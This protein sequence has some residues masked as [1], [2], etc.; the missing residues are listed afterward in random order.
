MHPKTHSSIAM[1]FSYPPYKSNVRGGRLGGRKW[2][3]RT[4]PPLSRIQNKQLNVSE[5]EWVCDIS[6]TTVINTLDFWRHKRQEAEATG[7]VSFQGHPATIWSCYSSYYTFLCEQCSYNYPHY[8]QHKKYD[9]R[10]CIQKNLSWNC[11]FHHRKHTGIGTSQV[12]RS[13]IMLF[14][15]WYLF[16]L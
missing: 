4:S 15:L 5:W 13:R 11:Y 10:T 8:L 1:I 3:K 14:S 12:P 16:L 7:L 2:V 6:R 9:D